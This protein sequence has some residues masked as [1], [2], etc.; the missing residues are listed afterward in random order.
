[1]VYETHSSVYEIALK[2]CRR[3]DNTKLEGAIV[4]FRLEIL[5]T[6]REKLYL[7]I[8]LNNS[9]FGSQKEGKWT[10]K[11]RQNFKKKENYRPFHSNSK[12]AHSS[13]IP[14]HS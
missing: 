8:R 11:G 5:A 1:M 13:S 3:G 4:F 7:C 2:E 6:K 10:L 12:A 14:F 9:T